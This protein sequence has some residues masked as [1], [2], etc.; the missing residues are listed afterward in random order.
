MHQQRSGEERHH[1]WLSKREMAAR[2]KRKQHRKSVINSGS[3]KR[4]RNGE[5]SESIESM[6]SGESGE[7]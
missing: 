7:A 6:K 4:N 5:E 2:R 1:Q 3:I